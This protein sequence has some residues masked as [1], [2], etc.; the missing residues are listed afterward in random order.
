M[1]GYFLRQTQLIIIMS[2]ALAFATVFLLPTTGLSP[3]WYLP[4]ALLVMIIAGLTGGLS[5]EIVTT[6]RVDAD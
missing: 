6:R 3:L 4:G 1:V 5:W 2:I